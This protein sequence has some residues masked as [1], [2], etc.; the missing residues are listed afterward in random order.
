MSFEIGDEAMKAAVK[1][2][3]WARALRWLVRGL[4]LAW[5]GFWVWFVIAVSVGEPPPPPWWIPA[6]WLSSL[7]ALV[8]LG[9]KRPTLGGLA[10]LGAGGWAAIY[11][12][13]P[14]ARALLAA[15]ALLL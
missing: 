6:A 12:A 13:T 1:E 4:M 5:A 15:P 10:F 3:A 7:T 8:L 11:F 9:W 2:S 14:G